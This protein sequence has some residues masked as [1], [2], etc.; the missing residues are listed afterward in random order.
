[1]AA[2]FITQAYFNIALLYCIFQMLHFLKI[3]GCGNLALSKSM[4]TI[5]EQHFP[6]CLCVTFW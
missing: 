1:M 5:S 6:P 3:E 2:L 4:D